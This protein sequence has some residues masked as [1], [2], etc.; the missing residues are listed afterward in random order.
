VLTA[1]RVQMPIAAIG[2]MWVTVL[3]LTVSG[4]ARAATTFNAQSAMGIN[5]AAVNYYASEQPFINSFVTSEQWITHSEAAWDTKEEKYL[6]LDA[7]GWPITLKSINE[8]TTQQFNS[9]GVLFLL[10]MP[11]TPNGIYPAGQYIVMYDGKGK[12]SYGLDAVL[13]RRSPGR[14]VINVTPSNKGIDLRIVETDPHNYLCNIKVI[15]AANEAAAKAGQIFNPAFLRLIRNFRA[16]RFMDWFLTNGSTLS[17]WTD[18]PIPTTAFFGTSKGVPIEIAVQLANAVSADA[19]MNVPVMADDNFIRQ[20]AT[21]VHS[22]LGSTQKIY[23][24]LSNEVWNSSFSQSKYAVD[25][26]KAL[27]PTRSSIDGDYEYDREWFGMRTAQMC[28]IWRSVWGSDPRLVC[29]LGAQAAWS[30]SATEA[31]KCPY[32]TQGAPCSGHA[33]DA[34]A[35]A[36]YMGGA[37]PSAWTSQADGGLTNLFRSLYSQNDPTTDDESYF[38]RMLRRWSRSGTTIPAGGFIAQDAAWEKDFTAN[39]APY[40]LPLLAYEGGQN[41]ADG[42]T[43]AL[44]T[45]YM[46]ANRDPRMGQAYTRYFQQWKAGGGQLFMHYSDIGVESKYGSWGAL[47]SIMQTTTPLSGAPPKWQAIQNFISGNPCWWPGCSGTIGARQTATVPA[48]ST[49]RRGM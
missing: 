34:V 41:F 32:W 1:S 9:L 13:V 42:S 12:L 37:V 33:I 24:E 46:A 48:V 47:E 49:N 7:N 10:G 15:T 40:K 39:L 2:L 30:F 5:L 3:I 19:W 44:N 6:N 20:M 35:I 36:P 43:N 29:V 4:G 31:L 23:V 11:N 16:L 45:L 18:R 25:R 26:G 21:L 22:Q 27:W 17:S 28:D 8:P 38:S 14:D